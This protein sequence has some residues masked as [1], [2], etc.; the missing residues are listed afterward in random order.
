MNHTV[1]QLVVIYFIYLAET[2]LQLPTEFQQKHTHNGEIP[3]IKSF[4]YSNKE[5]N[6]YD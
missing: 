2:A 1:S 5:A 4:I 3:I 6:G